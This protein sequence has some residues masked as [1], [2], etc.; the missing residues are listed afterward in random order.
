MSI[1]ESFGKAMGE[2]LAGL[3]FLAAI[4]AVLMGGYGIK[5]G[6]A[7]VKEKLKKRK[8]ARYADAT[9]EKE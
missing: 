2:T 1:R 8:E 4:A 3:V 7:K 5:E 9:P 6:Y